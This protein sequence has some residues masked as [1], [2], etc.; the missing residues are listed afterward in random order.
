MQVVGNKDGDAVATFS[1]QHGDSSTGVAFARCPA[2]Q[3]CVA[4]T[5]LHDS[6][7]GWFDHPVMSLGDDAEVTV[8]WTESEWV[9]DNEA[10]TRQLA[11]A[12]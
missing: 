5:Y 12:A 4:T 11:A 9:R 7:P 1:A 10:M 3:P 8:S 2:M 6:C